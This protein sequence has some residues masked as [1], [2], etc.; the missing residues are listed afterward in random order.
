MTIN[1]PVKNWLDGSNEEYFTYEGGDTLYHFSPSDCGITP[2]IAVCNVI[3][4]ADHPQHAE[5][6]LKRMLEFKVSQTYESDYQTRDKALAQRI[7]DNWD[8]VKITEA[9]TNQFFKVSWAG[10]DNIF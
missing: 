3:F 2:G 9:P 8:K 10:N 7:L 5:R 1:N 4:F 6:V